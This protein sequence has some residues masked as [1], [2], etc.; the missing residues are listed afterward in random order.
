MYTR[1]Q[2][3]SAICCSCSR[4]LLP[5]AN[6]AGSHTLCGCANLPSLQVDAAPAAALVVMALLALRR[7]CSGACCRCCCLHCLHT[8][9]MQKKAASAARL[10]VHVLRHSRHDSSA[11]FTYKDS[12][13]STWPVYAFHCPHAGCLVKTPAHAPTAARSAQSTHDGSAQSACTH[14]LGRF[15]AH[16]PPLTYASPS[17]NTICR[18]Y[19]SHA[20]SYAAC[21]VF[22]G[23]HVCCSRPQIG[24]LAAHKQ[25]RTHMPRHTA[26]HLHTCH[27]DGVDDVLHCAPI[28]PCLLLHLCLLALHLIPTRTCPVFIV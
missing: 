14:R 16:T 3:P 13:N 22:A 4:R 18:L 7:C 9:H 17:P 6:N 1:L 15:A 26:P 20:C 25:I 21:E 5:V 11:P 27:A 12:C 8:T 19:P 2:R 24:S 28:V 10:T 23:I